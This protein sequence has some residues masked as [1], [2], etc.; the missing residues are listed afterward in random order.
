MRAV[1]AEAGRIEVRDVPEPVAGP[2]ELLVRVRAAGLNRADLAVVAGAYVVGR[3]LGSLAAPGGGA[4]RGA[5][6]RSRPAPMGGEAAGEVVGVGPGVEAFGLGDRVMAMC[7]GAFAELVRIDARRALPVPERLS[8]EEAGACP[9]TFVT[10]HDA[11]ATAG[12]VRPGESVLVNA[13][14]SGVGVAA[15]QL[16]RLLGAGIVVASSTSAEKLDELRRAGLAFDAGL[17]AGAADF[18]ETALGATRSP[19][20]IAAEPAGGIDAESAG[21]ID[22][23]VDSVGGAAWADNLAVAALGGRIVSVGRLGGERADVNLDEVARKRV[24]L[25]GVTFRTRSPGEAAAV[26]AAAATDVVPALADGRLRVLVD[27]TF[28]LGDA[29]AAEQYLHTNRHVGKVVLVP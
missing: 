17:V 20:P 16:A 19:R 3:S 9:V 14:S 7:R 29:A 10:A 8:W 12:R 21:G 11:L 25:V 13:A 2:G 26:V 22:V 24:S 18:A 15:L 28:P 4:G 6:A 1:V 27:R 5:E 23:V